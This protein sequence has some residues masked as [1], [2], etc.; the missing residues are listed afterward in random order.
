MEKWAGAVHLLHW[1]GCACAICPTATSIHVSLSQAT[2]NVGE[3]LKHLAICLID[4]L[5]FDD[6]DR[7][8]SY[9]L[10]T[11]YEPSWIDMKDNVSGRGID[12][13]T[14][15]SSHRVRLGVWTQFHLRRQH[16]DRVEDD[17]QT[18]DEYLHEPYG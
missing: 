11:G 9:R 3:G 12:S 6:P 18:L 2:L 1:P 10:V 17:T 15:Q 16:A 4:H 14:G 7:C 5:S 13:S 8:Q